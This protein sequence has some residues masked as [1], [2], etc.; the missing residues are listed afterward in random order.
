MT[1]NSSEGPGLCLLIAGFINSCTGFILSVR[2]RL[3]D[4]GRNLFP[5]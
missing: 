2:G 4:G 1:G 5:D 3:A